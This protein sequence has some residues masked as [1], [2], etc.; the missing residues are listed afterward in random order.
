[1]QKAWIGMAAT[2]AL[3]LT[4][5][6]GP[7][8]DPRGIGKDETLVQVSATGRAE[9]RPD[10]ARF[11]VGVSSI[12]T[13]SE[14]AT[15]ANAAKINA[16]VEGM[17]ALGVAEG[18]M[19]TKQLTVSRIDWGANR[20]KYEAS[21]VVEV[22]MRAVD[23]VGAAIQAATRAG[24]NI[25]SGP[26]LRVSDTEGANRNAYA[27]AYKAARARADAYAEAAGLK[28]VRILVIRDGAASSP[29]IAYAADAVTEQA[30]A[31]APPPVMAGTSQSEVSVSVDFALGPK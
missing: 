12:A 25:L 7:G 21:N 10:E 17:K 14:A 19:Q 22:R 6:G 4:G 11:S 30:S 8:H 26:D 9:T 18:D 2:A 1:M 20:N 5:C 29:P 16:V 24:A 28:V 31:A 23:K 3:A 13:T 27:A 15:A